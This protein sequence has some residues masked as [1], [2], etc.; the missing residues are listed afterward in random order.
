MAGE[1][2]RPDGPRNWATYPGLFAGGG[3]DVMTLALL[4]QLPPSP[5]GGRVLDFACGS[6]TIAATLLA[7]AAARGDGGLRVHL[8]DADAVALH[9][10]RQNVP[11]ARRCFHCA[12]WPE[13]STE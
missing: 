2:A 8:L 6:G 12:G 11:G 4:A 1:P 5:A 7:R 3:L 9:A 10:A 13:T